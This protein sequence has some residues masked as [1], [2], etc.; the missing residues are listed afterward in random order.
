MSIEPHLTQKIKVYGKA[1]SHAQ[2]ALLELSLD[3]ALNGY[4]ITKIFENISMLQLR[5]KTEESV[6]H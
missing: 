6:Y 5:W 4:P 1:V 3:D 2:P